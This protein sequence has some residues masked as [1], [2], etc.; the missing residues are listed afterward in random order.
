VIFA[1]VTWTVILIL[2]SRLVKESSLDPVR[3]RQS[4]E[5]SS[6]LMVVH[7]FRPKEDAY[8]KGSKPS[9]KEK[10]MVQNTHLKWKALKM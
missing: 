7:E 6:S 2:Y 1:S 9:D 8:N 4:P 10:K 5:P 3:M